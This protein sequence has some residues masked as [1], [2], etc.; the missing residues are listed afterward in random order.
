MFNESKF[1]NNS[2]SDEQIST[3]DNSFVE[4]NKLSRES[5][6]ELD[7]K[8]EQL[9]DHTNLERRLLALGKNT[10][11]I[12]E[13][14][15]KFKGTDSF[16]NLRYRAAELE[17]SLVFLWGNFYGRYFK[18]LDQSIV[19]ELKMRP[20]EKKFKKLKKDFDHYGIDI[21]SSFLGTVGI[22]D[23]IW[24]F[25]P[26]VA[27]DYMVEN[28]VASDIQILQ[29]NMSKRKLEH[30]SKDHIL[31]EFT[32]DSPYARDNKTFNIMC[33]LALYKIHSQ[34]I[35]PEEN[36]RLVKAYLLPSPSFS[37]LRDSHVNRLYHDAH[38]SDSPLRITN[39]VLERV[40]EFND[41][42]FHPDYVLTDE[43]K[44]TVRES[45][46]KILQESTYDLIENTGSIDHLFELVSKIDFT[47]EQED[48]IYEYLFNLILERGQIVRAIEIL[49]EAPILLERPKYVEM[50]FDNLKQL[51]ENYNDRIDVFVSVCEKLPANIS[52]EHSQYIQKTYLD[53]AYQFISKS[54]SGSLLNFIKKQEKLKESNVIAKEDIERILVQAV[55]ALKDRFQAEVKRAG[56]D[57]G[58][59]YYLISLRNTINNV[60]DEYISQQEK[61]GLINQARWSESIT[62][63]LNLYKQS[64]R[65]EYDVWKQSMTPL[66]DQKQKEKR[67]SFEKPEDGNLVLD[68]VRKVGPLNL[69]LYFNLFQDIKQSNSI[70]TM[71][72]EIKRDIKESFDIDVDILCKN[73]PS[74]MDLIINEIEKYRHNIKVALREEKLEFIQHVIS[75]KYGREFFA[76]IKGKSGFGDVNVHDVVD[77]YTKARDKKKDRFET[78]PAY[79]EVDI[80]VGEYSVA[81]QQQDSMISKEIEKILSNS[82]LE[83]TYKR[84]AVTLHLEAKNATEVSLKKLNKGI[85]N[86]FNDAIGKIGE[87]IL[88]QKEQSNPNQ[89][90]IESIENKRK[91]IEKM[92]TSFKQVMSVDAADPIKLLENYFDNIPD[93]FVSKAELM[94]YLT[95]KDFRNRFSS[96]FPDVD[97]FDSDNI[98]ESGIATVTAF[99][100]DHISEHYLNKKH[101]HGSEVAIS[102]DD[103]DTLRYLRKIWGVNDFENNILSISDTKLNKLTQGELL[104]KKR[105]I[106]LV[107]SKGLLRMFSGDLGGACTS[108]RAG[109]LAAGKYEDI[110][111]YALVIDKDKKNERFGGSF[112]VVEAETK[113]KNP[114]LVL[115]ANNPSQSLIQTVDTDSLIENIISEV[116]NIAQRKGIQNI[117]VIL[118]NASQ[119][120]SNRVEV[121]SYY[122]RKFLTNPRVGLKKTDSTT[123]NGYDIHN[124]LG[125]HPVVLV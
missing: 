61:D 106:T 99:L 89:K 103:K 96:Q 105:D 118:D 55:Q 66:I 111:A 123:F 124:E 25:I 17:D 72:S 79:Q 31:V 74:N 27:K 49:T 20:L 39:P 2:N 107:P 48:K 53:L 112:L 63:M 100:R 9:E 19:T 47:S 81:M 65:V 98:T 68:Y 32:H 7:I 24:Q 54:Y 122:K 110:T 90:A 43:T 16:D 57:S 67:L 30:I 92:F 83:T 116:K 102:I 115:R 37:I 10:Q 94:R 60:P 58:D 82:E 56:Q 95:V 101:N 104:G 15:R 117:G 34:D 3:P 50:L 52:S 125:T 120:C 41:V 6:D 86:E 87:N 12:K 69:P 77:T 26:R 4:V 51:D 13:I 5:L 78:D 71:D 85:E 45:I 97:T 59:F 23:E 42:I 64:Q 70:A 18:D 14:V 35:D 114:I 80:T 91:E 44:S 38:K 21:G 28:D 36:N 1:L 8:T 75:T 93:A 29:E 73:D 113:D 88:K 11:E 33:G 119:A 22:N 109:E 84:I 62:D 108:N 76:S 46:V 121:S 40:K